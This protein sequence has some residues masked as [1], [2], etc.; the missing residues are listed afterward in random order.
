MAVDATTLNW[1]RIHAGD[2][3]TDSPD[4][5]NTL[6][7]LVWVDEG[8]PTDTQS[9]E[10]ARVIVR[11][12]EVRLAVVGNDVQATSEHGVY[13]RD[14]KFSRVERLLKMWRSKAQ[15]T[16]DNNGAITG[17]VIGMGIDATEDDETA[18]L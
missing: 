16:S 11:V 17:G 9:V 5:S 1:I 8:S 15:D 2:T 7:E 10:Y 6:I 13:N 4:V 14:T 18:V 12:L 3:N